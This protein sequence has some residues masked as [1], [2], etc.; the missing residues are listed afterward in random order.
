MQDLLVVKDSWPPVP[1]D[2]AAREVRHLFVAQKK[3]EKDAAKKCQIRKAL[4]C[5]ALNRLRRQQRREGLPIEES[6]SETASE[7]DEDEGSDDNGAESRYDTMTFLAHLPDVQSLQGPVG[8][9]STSQVLRVASSPIEG[10]KEPAGG[11]AREGP[12]E[13]VSTAPG[14]L[15][16]TSMAPRPHVRSPQTSLAGGPTTLMPETRASSS[17]VRTHG[18]MASSAQR[19]LE[20]LS[21]QAPRSS[22]PSGGLME[23]LS[24]K[25]SS[26]SGTLG[27]RPLI[28]LSR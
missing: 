26:G 2:H 1:K 11:R 24:Q 17:G 15:P 16:T 22:G 13:K 5:E 27:T 3:K 23:G 18:Q 8:G 12:S 9:G 25:P 19:T 4:E 28:P 7:E 6:P 20:A 14:G 21:A 10:E